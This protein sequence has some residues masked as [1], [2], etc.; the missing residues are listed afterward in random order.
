VSTSATPHVED[1]NMSEKPTRKVIM[2]TKLQ[3]S[4]VELAK[5]VTVLS[6]LYDM[7]DHYTRGRETPIAQRMVN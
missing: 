4:C 2:L 7:I 1:D 5:D 3:K 6:T